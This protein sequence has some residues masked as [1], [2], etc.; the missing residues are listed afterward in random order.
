MHKINSWHHGE[1]VHYRL[2]STQDIYEATKKLL[3]Q[4]EIIRNVR[5]LAINVFNL[6]PWEPVQ[7]SLFEQTEDWGRKIGDSPHR[8][9]ESRKRVSDAV[10]AINNRYGEF[11]ITPAAMLDMQGTILDRIAFGQVKDM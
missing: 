6:E 11:V 8:S 4:A 2:Y 1:K 10:D 7:T 9:Y 5:I 3:N